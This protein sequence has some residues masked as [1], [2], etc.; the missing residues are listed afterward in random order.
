MLRK[1]QQQN[2][3]EIKHKIDGKLYILF[4]CIGC[5]FQKFETIDKE[6]LNDL[7]QPY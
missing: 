4:R 5:S 3:I 7:L 6:E 2:N 1:Y